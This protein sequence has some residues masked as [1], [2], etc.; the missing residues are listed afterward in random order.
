MPGFVIR[1]GP[2]ETHALL[3]IAHAEYRDP[4]MQAR[5]LLEEAIRS[6]GVLPEEQ[7]TTADHR[8]DNQASVGA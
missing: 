1:L 6:R 3:R 2:N 8:A 7:E 5:L 4:R